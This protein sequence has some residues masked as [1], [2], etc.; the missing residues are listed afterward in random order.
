[1]K[2]TGWQTDGLAGDTVIAPICG[3]GFSTTMLLVTVLD[4][5]WELEAVSDTD[6]EPAVAK[7]TPA[8][9]APSSSPGVPPRNVHCQVVGEPVEVSVNVTG[10]PG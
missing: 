6:F 9:S 5:G 4:G 10:V 3:A 2:V 8:G 7:V 1:M